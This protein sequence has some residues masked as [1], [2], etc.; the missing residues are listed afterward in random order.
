MELYLSGLSVTLSLSEKT[1]DSL[2]RVSSNSLVLVGDLEDLLIVEPMNHSLSDSISG[3]LGTGQQGKILIV[4][5]HGVWPAA[6]LS[7]NANKIF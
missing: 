7:I 6:P 2:V 1:T 4:S 3:Q 5:G